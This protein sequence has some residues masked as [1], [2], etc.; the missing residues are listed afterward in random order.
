MVLIKLAADFVVKISKAL[1]K[2]SK[3]PQKFLKPQKE[4]QI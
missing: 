1:K 4:P 3:L 2:T